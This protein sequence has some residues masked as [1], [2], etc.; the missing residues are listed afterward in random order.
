MRASSPTPNA[1]VN[2]FPYAVTVCDAQG[3][4]AEMNDAATAAF[5]DSGGRNLIGSDLLACH[6]EHAQGIVKGL[7]AT[8]RPNIYT[9]E[10]GGKQ[11]LIVQS[12]W[13]RDGQFA[14][15]V[16]LSIVLPETIPHFVRDS[17]NPPHS[18]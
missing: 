9:I 6:P 3:I 12:P 15:I 7:L 11:K 5:H 16:E 17:N 8:A 4:I 1:W 10:K 2:E 14:G 13:Y 18:T